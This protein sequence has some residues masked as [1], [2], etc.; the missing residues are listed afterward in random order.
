MKK[1]MFKDRYGL[2]QAV[3]EGRKTMTL[4]TFKSA[5]RFDPDPKLAVAREILGITK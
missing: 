3:L 5:V 4:E 2:T 1:I